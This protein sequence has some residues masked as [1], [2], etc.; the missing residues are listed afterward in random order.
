MNIQM[1]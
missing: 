1:F